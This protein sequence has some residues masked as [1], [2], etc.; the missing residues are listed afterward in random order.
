MTNLILRCPAAFCQ[1]VAFRIGLP[2]YPDRIVN[3]FLG[4]ISD[5]ISS[6]AFIS[7]SCIEDAQLRRRFGCRTLCFRLD[8]GSQR[9]ARAPRTALLA[10]PGL[11]GFCHSAQCAWQL[12]SPQLAGRKGTPRPLLR[13]QP[14]SCGESGTSVAAWHLLAWA[15]L[16]LIYSGKT[17]LASRIIT[18]AADQVSAHPGLGKAG[19]ML[20]RE[21]W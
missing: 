7:P 5:A 14:S 21:G 13:R 1:L 18:L 10:G 6:K 15:W 3:N 8:L 12:R 19:G 16:P 11:G 17:C 20:V 9:C 4:R 2:S